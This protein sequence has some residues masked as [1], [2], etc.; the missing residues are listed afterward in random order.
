MLSC[1]LSSD[2]TTSIAVNLAGA[3]LLLPAVDF[4]L[5]LVSGNNSHI[6]VHPGDVTVLTWP[7][8]LGPVEGGAGTGLD[9]LLIGRSTG[10]VEIID[11][12]DVATL[13]WT[14][15]GHCSRKNGLLSK[16]FLA[17]YDMM[18]ITVM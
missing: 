16:I 13:H 15:L 12:F 3:I 11:V 8:E 9:S 14:G 4:K 17:V 18:L 10:S 1:E 6:D 2:K 7:Q 5:L